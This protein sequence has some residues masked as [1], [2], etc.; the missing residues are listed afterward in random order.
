MVTASIVNTNIIMVFFNGHQLLAGRPV[1]LSFTSGGASNGVYRVISTTNANMFVVDTPDGTARSTN[2]CL[3]PKITGGGYVQNSTNVTVTTPITH[4]LA[5][6]DSIFIDFV[7][8]QG[9]DG[10]YQVVTTPTWTNFTVIAPTAVNR[11]QNG[12][13][14]FPLAAPDLVRSGN[15]A[16][17]WSTFSVGATDT[18]ASASLSQT[19]LNSPSVFNFFF[20]DFK[21]PGV[22]AAAGLTTPEFMLTSDTE[23]MFQM[24]YLAGGIGLINSGNNTNGLTSFSSNDGDIVMDIGPWMG[25]NYTSNAG[26]P[27]LVDTLNS[28]LMA[29]QLSPGARS[30]IIAYVANTTNF[31]YGN[32]PTANQR[33]D[34]VRA[35]IHLLLTSPDF[36]I[37]R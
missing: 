30:V 19:P 15:V 10:T 9:I 24:N 13:I 5:P 14:M 27:A 20:P 28:L 29:G 35:V 22:L 17:R 4:G 21:F 6:G 37:Q 18:G 23:V 3:V 33:R 1:Y 16:I 36:T 8:G 34:R 32:P 11:T 2:N 26:I 25:T 12:Q 31:P 7:A